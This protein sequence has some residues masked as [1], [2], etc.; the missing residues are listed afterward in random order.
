MAGLAWRLHRAGHA[1]E[2]LGYV[3]AMERFDR[4]GARVRHRLTAVAD[5]SAPYAVIG[6]SLGGLL[7]RAALQDWPATR[8]LPAALI[9]LGSPVKPPRLA[10]RLKDRWWFRLG[11]GD[12]GQRLAE[13][14]FFDG[15]SMPPVPWLQIAGTAG[16]R[17]HK[18]PFGDELNDGVVALDEA[19]LDIGAPAPL[20]TH[21]WHTFLM[22]NR[23]AWQGIDRLL[24][25]LG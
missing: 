16:W 17:G 6:H 14:A 25:R 3:A 4:I 15:L 8:P 5:R 11:A 7:A 24:T 22:N 9:T 10:R 12:C 2:S 18:S 13:P 1:T 20:T 23:Q 21:A 19:T